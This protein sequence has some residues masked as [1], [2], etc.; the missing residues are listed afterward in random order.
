MHYIGA[1][2]IIEMKSLS[3]KLAL[4]LLLL[5]SVALEGCE[6]PSPE[7]KFHEAESLY[8]E[9]KYDEALKLVFCQD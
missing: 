5:F 2:N 3:T 1:I 9:G 6:S 8:N 7:Q 4:T